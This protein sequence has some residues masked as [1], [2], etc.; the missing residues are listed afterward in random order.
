MPWRSTSRSQ[1]G[2][3]EAVYTELPFIRAA[4]AC[5]GMDS[6][7]RV[8]EVLHVIAAAASNNEI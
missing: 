2:G 5:A 4:T 8:K 6:H 1:I 7:E 3:E